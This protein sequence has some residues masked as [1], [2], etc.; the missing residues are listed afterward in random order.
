MLRSRLFVPVLSELLAERL[1]TRPH[2]PGN[3]HLRSPKSLFMGL[4]DQSTRF[5]FSDD[6]LRRGSDIESPPPLRGQ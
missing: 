2:I 4:H 6:E 1:V 3:E 5:V